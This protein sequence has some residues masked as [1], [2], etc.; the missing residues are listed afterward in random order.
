MNLSLE[1]AAPERQRRDDEALRLASVEHTGFAA[2]LAGG[3]FNQRHG[4]GLSFF[5][6]RGDRDETT[7][8]N[9]GVATDEGLLALE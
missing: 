6:A 9:V 8:L 2:R 5:A 7:E 4:L 1:D 3:A